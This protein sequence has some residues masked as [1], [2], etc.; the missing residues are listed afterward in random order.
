[1]RLAYDR[2]TEPVTTSA[3][4]H[5]RLAVVGYPGKRR[6]DWPRFPSQ[7]KDI[8][9]QLRAAR[10]SSRLLLP[11]RSGIDVAQHRRSSSAGAWV[12]S[13]SLR[14]GC[15]PQTDPSALG[16]WSRFA[17]ATLRREARTTDTP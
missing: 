3:C 13:T 12:L 1:M 6:E 11:R 14:S 17:G 4:Q 10:N 8:C 15:Q 5:V 7:P 16:A 9:Q 2:E